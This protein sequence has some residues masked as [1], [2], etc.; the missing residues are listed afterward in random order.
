MY[1]RVR[2]RVD[3]Y[4]RI[5]VHVRELHVARR[6]VRLSGYSLVLRESIRVHTYV[7]TRTRIYARDLQYFCVSSCDRA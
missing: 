3:M 4:P 5:S 2:M 1:V 7:H 6:T